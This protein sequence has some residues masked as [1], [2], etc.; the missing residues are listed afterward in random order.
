MGLVKTNPV[1]Q[2]PRVRASVDPSPDYLTEQEEAKLF[3]LKED[4]RYPWLQRGT[5]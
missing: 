3:T 4:Q 2:V 5:G 1:R